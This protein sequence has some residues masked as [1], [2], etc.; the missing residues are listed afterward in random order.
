MLSTLPQ[1]HDRVFPISVNSVKLTWRRMTAKLGIE[2][3]HFHDLRHEA[4]VVVLRAW[5]GHAG[6]VDHIWTPGL[7]QPA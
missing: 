1:D 4:R 2:D 5:F 7:A 3:L 6:G